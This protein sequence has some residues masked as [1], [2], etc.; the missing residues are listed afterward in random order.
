MR[1]FRQFSLSKNFK[2]FLAW[3]KHL[4]ENKLE[5]LIHRHFMSVSH[6]ALFYAMAECD[7]E[8]TFIS[9]FLINIM[10]EQLI[11]C[12]IVCY[13]IIVVYLAPSKVRQIFPARQQTLLLFPY[14]Q[15]DNMSKICI[16][17]NS[18]SNAVKNNC[19]ISFRTF[20]SYITN[21]DEQKFLI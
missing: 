1:I 11:I 14:L 18:S 8:K 5:I 15:H 20:L 17:L 3:S 2:Q 4:A 6:V 19:F 21:G 13:G 7:F 12:T 9:I 16:K 10:L